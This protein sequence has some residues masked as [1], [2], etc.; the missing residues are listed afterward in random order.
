MVRGAEDIEAL[1]LVVFYYHLCCFGIGRRPHNR[2]KPWSGTVN[3]FDPA[4]SQD[5]VISR[6]DPDL[7]CLNI[8]VFLRDIKIGFIKYPYCLAYLIG[9]ECCHTRIEKRTE[10]WKMILALYVRGKQ[11][12]SKFHWFL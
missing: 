7:T 9:K 11:T 1:P 2:G 4:F 12:A 5:C 10:V 8:R 6:T 3:K